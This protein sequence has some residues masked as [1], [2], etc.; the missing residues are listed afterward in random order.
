LQT[1]TIHPEARSAG[2][3]PFGLYAIMLLLALMAV[4]PA[5]DIIGIQ[6]RYTSPLLEKIVAWLGDS[7][8]LLNL[9]LRLDVAEHVL[10]VIDLTIIGALATLI[11]GLWFRLRW[12]WIGTMIVIGLGLA[13][14]IRVYLMGEPSYLN[15]VVHV[16]AV[17]YLNER[18]VQLAFERRPDESRR[19]T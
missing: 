19:A 16:I 4:L 7:A 6:V 14:N 18:G 12:A 11:F 2:R 1:E 13:H 8:G 17:F 3:R 9:F 5:L 10:I 15:M